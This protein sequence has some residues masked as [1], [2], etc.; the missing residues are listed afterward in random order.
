[1]AKSIIDA[2]VILRYLLRDDESLFQKASALLEK[3]KTGEETALIPE[4]VLAE[5]VYVLL[6]IYGVEREVIAEKLRGLLAYKGV[7]NPDK[8]ILMDSLEL[9]GRTGLSIVDCII[10]SMSI[11]GRIP[12]FTFDEDLRKTCARRSP[13]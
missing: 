4:S 11:D 8:R 10:C 9:F 5:C 7:V 12:L 2:N 6:K 3:V 13:P 1:M